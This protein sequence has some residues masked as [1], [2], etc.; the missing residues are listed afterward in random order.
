[1]KSRIDFK[2]YN[3]KKLNMFRDSQIKKMENS[4][5]QLPISPKS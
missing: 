4:L 2:K 1:M 5:N 3:D